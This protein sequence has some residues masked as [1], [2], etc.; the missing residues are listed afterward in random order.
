MLPI[1]ECK[2]VTVTAASSVGQDRTTGPER[3]LIPGVPFP[4]QHSA[5]CYTGAMTTSFGD[6][7]QEQDSRSRLPSIRRPWHRSL[8][9]LLAVVE[10]VASEVLDQRL[11]GRSPDDQDRMIY[12]MAMSYMMYMERSGF[13]AS[14]CK[15]CPWTSGR[16]LLESL[17][18][19]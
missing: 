13:S 11:R 14:W 5:I 10:R 7:N 4:E 15:I 12:D 3:C 17:S 9:E 16:K 2:R 18:V 8:N 1:H 19:G 6:A